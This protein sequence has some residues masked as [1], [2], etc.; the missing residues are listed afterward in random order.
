MAKTKKTP[1]TYF[2]DPRIVYSLTI[3]LILCGSALLSDWVE[4]HWPYDMD[5]A[6]RG[7]PPS[8][9]HPFG[10]DL[11]GGELWISLIRGARITLYVMGLTVLLSFSV[12]IAVGILTGYC[13][14]W[15]DTV[16]MRVLDIVMAFPGI[17]LAMAIT[18]I[19]GPSV[20]TLIFAIA[21]TGWTGTARLVRGQVMS[22]KER[23]YVLAALALGASTP[24][25]LWIY[26]LPSLWS[27]LLISAAFS[28]SGVLLVE[29]GL[30]FLGLG[31][32]D[33]A[34]TWG[35]LLNQGRSV[36]TESPHLSVIPGLCILA[37]V[38]ALNFLGEAL[39]DYLDP[40]S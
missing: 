22:L 30:S 23:E 37:T 16:L 4:M 21:A 12:G 8:I 15:L 19:M 24:R 13:G 18:A 3:L 36:L 28:L 1:W 35:S 39:R 34:P 29:A 27:V 31:A 25:I 10:C 2:A 26:I 32:Q 14:G 5:L 20:H 9:A 40:R 6:M 17:L 38:L 33:G 11:N 7:L